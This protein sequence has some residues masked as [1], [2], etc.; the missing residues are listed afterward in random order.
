MAEFILKDQYGKEKVFDHDK[1]FV[2]GT[3]GELV[4][5]TQGAGVSPDV[6]YVTFMS[7]DGLTEYG[8]KPVAVGDDCADPIARGIFS[9]PTREWDGTY[10]YEFAEKW[11]ET[12]GGNSNGTELQDVTENKTLYAVFNRVAISYRGTCGTN[13]QWRLNKNGTLTIYGTGDMTTLSSSTNYPWNKYLSSIKKVVIEDGVTSIGDYAFRDY[14]N[15]TSVSIPEGISA[16]PTM[17]F[18]GCSKLNNVIIPDSCTTL[19]MSVFNGCTNLK[20]IN[21]PNGVVS[22]NQHAFRSCTSLLSVT[23][24]DGLTEINSNVFNGCTNLQS[25]NI[26]DECTSIGSTAFGGCTSLT[27]ITIPANVSSVQNAFDGCSN[28][29]SVT[30]IGGNV[31]L[32]IKYAAFQNCNSLTSIIIPERVNKIGRM[33]FNGCTSLVDATFI[34][35]VGWYVADKDTA[36]SGTDI[37]SADLSNKSTAA[38]Y[39]TSTYV[40]QYWLRT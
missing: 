25:V 34:T 20:S 11:S 37:P 21:I 24:P 40:G 29:S 18:M 6:C 12:I 10:D 31:S 39:L 5:F 1:I 23:L 27:S 33:A 16:L 7:Y 36:T 2:Q 28:L 30:I 35:P 26:P 4:Q 13:V 22:I 15:L 9:T 17:C 38:T 3:D 32:Y 14:T 8:K 19:G